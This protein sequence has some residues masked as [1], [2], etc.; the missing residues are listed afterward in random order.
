L[1]EREANSDGTGGL[2][3]A[4]YEI[5]R[6][7]FRVAEQAELIRNVSRAVAAADVLCGLA[8]VA[9][10]QGYW[11][12][13][14]KDEGLGI[15]GRPGGGEVFAIWVFCAEFDD[16]GSGGIIQP[17]TQPQVC[18]EETSAELCKQKAL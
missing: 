2:E 3:P 8:E 9:V 16:S 5:L 6:L 4:E 17:Q 13:W 11:T 1:K 12:L 18:S 14:L 7:T 15:D 10:Y